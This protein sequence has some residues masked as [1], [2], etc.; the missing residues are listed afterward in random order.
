MLIT[1]SWEDRRKNKR[2]GPPFGEEVRTETNRKNQARSRLKLAS[3]QILSVLVLS[4]ALFFHSVTAFAKKIGV[5]TGSFDPPTRAHEAIV[6]RGMSQ[7]SIDEMV[8]F[9][10]ATSDV[11]NFNAGVDDRM[12][13][14]KSMFPDL[15]AKVVV[16][17]IFQETKNLQIEELARYRDEIYQ[18]VGEDSF[19][20]I[21]PA[22]F[23]DSKRMWVVIP[24]EG[25]QTHPIPKKKNI[26]ILSE[27]ETVKSFSS[28]QFRQSVKIG[29]ER[30]EML[31]PEVLQYI[32]AHHFYGVAD[33]SCDHLMSTMPKQ[34]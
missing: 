10:N 13:M 21:P 9:V 20:K 2:S 7:Y 17:P 1:S 31:R 11:K 23:S 15:G 6:R 18:F 8:V 26:F 29:S 34:Q 25:Y 32:Q 24:R 28:T 27:D 33:L 16:K 19:E 30:S 5:Y 22:T 12:Q 4:S 14:V 3:L